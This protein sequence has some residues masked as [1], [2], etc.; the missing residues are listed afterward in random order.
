MTA[1][2]AIGPSAGWARNYRRKRRQRRLDLRRER[3]L[4][5]RGAGLSDRS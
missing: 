5:A 2:V 1:G 4:R 3:V